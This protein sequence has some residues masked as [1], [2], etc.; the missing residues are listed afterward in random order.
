MPAIAS[1]AFFGVTSP[2]GVA[3]LKKR[4]S[5]SLATVA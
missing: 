2:V 5:Q 3:G 4:A 1:S